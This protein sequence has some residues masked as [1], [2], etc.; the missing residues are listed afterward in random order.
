MCSRQPGNRQRFVYM[1]CLFLL[2]ALALASCGSSQ[3]N[4]ATPTPVQAL[5]TTQPT[6]TISQADTTIGQLIQRQS[7]SGSILVASHGNILLDK[8]YGMADW[9]RKLKNAPQTQFA[10]GDMTKAFTATAILMLQ[11]QGKLNVQ[12]S[13]CKYISGCPA[14]WQPITIQMLLTNTSGIA[15]QFSQ[16]DLQA[17]LALPLTP[18]RNITYI[19]KQPLDSPPGAAFTYN[20]PAFIVLGTLIQVVSGQSYADFVRQHMLQP[21]HMS[22]TVVVDSEAAASQLTDLATGYQSWQQPA[23]VG[24]LDFLSV[25]APAIGIVSTVED[26]YRWNQALTAHTLLSAQSVQHMFTDYVKTDVNGGCIF[27]VPMSTTGTCPD[28]GLGWSVGK[29]AG[30]TVD[31]IAG[32]FTGYLCYMQRFPD[33]QYTIIVLTNQQNS[34]LSTISPTLESVM[35]HLTQ[36]L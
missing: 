31:E 16:A 15:R 34:D 23:S 17:T 25:Y 22:H 18:D 26:L 6:I 19:K 3:Q 10:I 12:D 8:G 29:E 14:T 30:H 35:F 36:S 21:L 24:N 2:C 28:Y 33:D 11:Q 4:T 32:Y 7:F 13:V 20:T 1:L 27:F 9:Q 5:P